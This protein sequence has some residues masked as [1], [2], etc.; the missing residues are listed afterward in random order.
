[1]RLKPTLN[2]GKSLKIQVGTQ[3]P[4]VARKEWQNLSLYTLI[5]KAHQGGTF[6][7]IKYENSHN[8]DEFEKKKGYAKGVETSGGCCQAS[9]RQ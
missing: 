6:L 2:S 9:W 5:R 8:Y 1:M 4:T 3:I 7:Y